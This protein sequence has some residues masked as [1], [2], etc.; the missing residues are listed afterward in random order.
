PGAEPAILRE[1]L[2]QSIQALGDQLAGT[3]RQRRR[4]FVDLDAGDR[5]RGLDHLDQ[6]RAVLGALADGL[7]VEDDAGNVFRHRFRRAKQKLA[8]IAAAVP[9]RFRAAPRQTLR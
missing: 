4:A 5:A 7:V 9:R 8:A 1:A 2:S 6:W 3:E